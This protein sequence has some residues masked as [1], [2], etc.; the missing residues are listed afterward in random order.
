MDKSRRAHNI[1]ANQNI[2]KLH[3]QLFGVPVLLTTYRHRFRNSNTFYNCIFVFGVCLF[4]LFF[5]F[6]SFGPFCCCCCFCFG[7]SG[8]EHFYGRCLLLWVSWHSQIFLSTHTNTHTHTWWGHRQTHIVTETQAIIHTNE[9][10]RIATQSA[11]EK[12]NNNTITKFGGKKKN[13]QR[14]QRQQQNANKLPYAVAVVF[15]IAP[16][17]HDQHRHSHGF[18][19]FVCT[20]TFSEKPLENS[21]P[22]H[23]AEKECDFLAQFYFFLA[24]IYPFDTEKRFTVGAWPS[25]S[26]SLF[27]SHQFEANK[28]KV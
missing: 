27:L 18:C 5:L 3:S 26:L 7:F 1:P 4:A 21:V 13:G 24:I 9:R 10:M 22:T 25:L 23:A 14:R 17:T 12:N 28:I 15:K 6:L 2:H 16:W 11:H 19:V 20:H 8:F